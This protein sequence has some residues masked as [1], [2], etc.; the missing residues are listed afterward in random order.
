MYT[1]PDYFYE[2]WRE[3]IQKEAEAARNLKREKRRRQ[4][5]KLEERAFE[6]SLKHPRHPRQSRF[7]SP[8]KTT[9]IEICFSLSI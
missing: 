8:A 9:F 1:N 6:L 5:M 2:L 7:A 4:K 3:Q